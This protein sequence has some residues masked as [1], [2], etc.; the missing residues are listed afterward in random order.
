MPAG[1][2]RQADFPQSRSQLLAEFVP[3]VDGLLATEDKSV[4]G[5]FVPGLE[6]PNERARFLDGNG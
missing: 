4:L 6:M 2:Y 3:F 1:S 5:W